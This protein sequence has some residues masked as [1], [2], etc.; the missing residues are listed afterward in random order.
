MHNM[1]KKKLVHDKMMIGYNPNVIGGSF[2]NSR[3]VVNMFFKTL[4]VGGIVGLITSFFVKGQ[5]YLN[6]INPFNGLELLGVFLFFTG[7]A[8]VFTVVSQTGFFAYLFIHRFGQNFFRSFWPTVQ[9]LL[10]AFALFDLIYFSSK[11]ISLLFKIMMTAFILIYGLIIARIKV[12]QTNKTA[13]IPALF[14]MVVVSALQL[15]LVL[16][17]GDVSFI[18]LML[19]PLLAANAYQLLIL[20]E[21]TKV[22]EEH[23]RRIEERR[24]QRL[25]QQKRKRMDK[26]KKTS[27]AKS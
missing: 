26:V 12:K 24:K 15:S 22:D 8:L 20:H 17:A 2:V 18:I 7:Y 3:K 14:L 6:F 16:R 19:M 23:K 5:E 9:V 1:K 4:F 27:D 25:E 10:V 11:E 21:V 13:F